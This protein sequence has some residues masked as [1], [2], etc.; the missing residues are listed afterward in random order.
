M[1][2]AEGALRLGEEEEGQSSWN[3]R[4]QQVLRQEVG[5][6]EGGWGREH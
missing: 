2:N 1:P 6:G 5:G 4:K 3:A